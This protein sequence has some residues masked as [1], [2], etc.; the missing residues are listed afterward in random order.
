[1]SS[2]TQ[3]RLR[4]ALLLLSL[5]VMALAVAAPRTAS[6]VNCPER[7]SDEKAARKMAS[8]LYR[9]GVEAFKQGRYKKAKRFFTCTQRIL[10][11]GLTRYWIGRCAEKLGELRQA[12]EIL[13]AV[14]QNPPRVVDKAKL[15]SRIVRLRKRVEAKSRTRGSRTSRKTRRARR[16]RRGSG[17][18]GGHGQK[19]ST[20]DE[21]RRERLF[22][23]RI[24][25]WASWGLGAAFLI[26]GTV[27]G[28][29]VIH[30]QRELEN[31][32]DGKYWDP[33]LERRYDRRKS[34]APGAWVCLGLG[35]GAAVAGTVLYFLSRDDS[36][37]KADKDRS[38]GAQVVP[39]IAPL[40]GGGVAGVTIRY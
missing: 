8:R 2:K 29:V 11:A 33:A 9:S 31:A 27:L 34:L 28:S 23:M 6:A 12:L 16:S 3:K 7:P 35:I 38:R 24:S 26:T 14:A 19:K 25:G 13:S 4:R 32:T 39:Q 20:P 15:E 18:A 22:W 30:D 37:E 36:E 5:S 40:P 1:M 17:K 21:K 10:P